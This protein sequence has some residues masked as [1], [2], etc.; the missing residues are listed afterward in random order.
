MLCVRMP[1]LRSAFFFFFLP[2]AAIFFGKFIAMGASPAR[3]GGS[4][5]TDSYGRGPQPLRKTYFV[6]TAV[7][8][9]NNQTLVSLASDSDTDKKD[10]VNDLMSLRA[11]RL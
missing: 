11:H 6:S 7:H 3:T 10:V 8:H 1:Q 2:L 9:N 5:Q 4:Q